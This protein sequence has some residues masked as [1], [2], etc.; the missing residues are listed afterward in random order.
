[1]N[2]YVLFVQ[3]QRCER[4]IS[5]LNKNKNVTAFIP[6]MEM[7]RRDSTELILDTM[8]PGYVFVKTDMDQFE[9]DQFL[10]HL[11]EQK[12]GFIKELKKE[13]VSSL[14]KEEI[15]FIND[16]LDDSFILRMSYGA[17]IDGRSIPFKG[18]LVK[19]MNHIKRVNFYRNIAYLDMEFM[20]RAIMV[21][22]TV[23][24]AK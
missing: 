12:K 14:T 24:K 8:F 20:H 11:Q 15:E 9:F 3:T 1:M 16:F 21:G 6:K 10:F 5:V 22:F 7:Y 18:P 17:R 19:Y 2:Y 23:N 4:L 13:D